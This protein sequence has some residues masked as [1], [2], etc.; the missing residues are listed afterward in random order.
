[1]TVNAQIFRQYDIRGIVGSDLTEETLYLIGKGFGTYLNNRNLKT[2]AIGG[3]A[4]PSTPAFKAQFIKGLIETGCDVTDIGLCATPVL[5]FAIWK[6]GVQG[7][8]MITAS[9]NPSEYNGIKLNEG[10]ASVYGE[11]IQEVLQIIQKGDFAQGQGSVKEFKGIID[12][13]SDYLVENIKLKRPIK[14][15]VDAG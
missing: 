6:L 15:V 7:G 14:C 8:A 2:V 5:Y 12:V 13:Y 3:D 10:L 4:R 1:M 11:Q 9:H